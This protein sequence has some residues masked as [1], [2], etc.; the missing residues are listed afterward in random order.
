MTLKKESKHDKNLAMQVICAL[1]DAAKEVGISKNRIAKETGYSQPNVWKILNG[2]TM[3]TLSTLCDICATMKID[4]AA[5]IRL[6]M[7]SSP[8]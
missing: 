2:D 4:L 5:A 6:Y 3:P 7:N 8:Q 1:N